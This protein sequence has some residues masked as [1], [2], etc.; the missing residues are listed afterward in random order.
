MVRVII[1]AD[2]IGLTAGVTRGITRAML[3]GVA[4]SATFMAA[5]PDAEVAAAAIVLHGLDVGVHLNITQGRPLA[6]RTEVPSLVD[7]RGIFWNP[8]ELRSR[9]RRSAI[10]SKDVELEFSRQVERTLEL[11]IHPTHLD[12]HHHVH[13]SLGIAMALY[14]VARRYGIRGV[15]TVRAYD[16][17]DPALF[18]RLE[19]QDL[20]RREARA[21]LGDDGEARLPRAPIALLKPGG[22]IAEWVDLL[23][24]LAPCSDTSVFE[25]ICHPAVADDDL[26]RLSQFVSSREAEL[27]VVTSAEVREAVSSLGIRLI[28]YGDL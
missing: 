15:R 17:F 9:A 7:D 12:S 18:A 19:R 2:D 4:T 25:I 13:A 16:T 11:G 5:M 28:S 3:H 23:G 6:Q 8:G 27:R 21:S 14:R 24:Q 22:E 26:S 1:N 10:M 20:A